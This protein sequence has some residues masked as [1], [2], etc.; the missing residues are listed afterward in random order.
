[1]K[2]NTVK[3]VNTIL[4]N[5]L[6]TINE[7]EEIL[8]KHFQ[9]AKMSEVGEKYE[10][11]IY[12]EP[13][14]SNLSLASAIVAYSDAISNSV[15]HINAL[16]RFISLHVP[17]M[18]DG[19]NFGVTVQLTISKFLQETKEKLFKG[20]ERIPAYYGNRA[21]AIDKLGISK[22]TI[23]ETVTKTVSLVNG[24]KDGDENKTSSSTVNEEKCTG[25][26]KN[27]VSRY[28]IK[29]L[30]SMDTQLYMDLRN[31]LVDCVNSYLTILD[32]MEK[33]KDK[34]ISPKG[35]YGGNSMGMY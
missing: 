33:N 30:A 12:D 35:S 2:N 7:M 32:N 8:N 14:A 23:S 25:V 1:V 15:D 34:L 5:G 27:M 19:N 17:Q 28:R 29:H 4:A 10:N 24:G 26:D 21:D 18:E 20:L 3:E 16:E 11:E 22:S 6:E 9:M 31:G 13:G